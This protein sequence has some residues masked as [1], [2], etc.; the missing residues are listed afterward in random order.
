MLDIHIVHYKTCNVETIDS[1]QRIS[2]YKFLWK[3]WRDKKWG[4]AVLVTQVVRKWKMCT[5]GSGIYHS[6]MHSQ[7]FRSSQCAEVRYRNST[8]G[9][10]VRWEYWQRGW[11][12]NC[13][14][15]LGALP[16]IG[17]ETQHV[18]DIKTNPQQKTQVCW[19]RQGVSNKNKQG[20]RARES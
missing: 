19:K 17:A 10:V 4:E 13:C 8:G 7:T 6:E 15:G 9:K 18:R 2:P 11:G 20:V 5:S 1:Y 16:R 3:S 12:R 14:S